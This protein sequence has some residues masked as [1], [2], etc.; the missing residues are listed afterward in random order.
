MSDR[1]L[2]GFDYPDIVVHGAESTAPAA[3]TVL[4]DSLA[5]PVAG[6]WLFIV[7]VASNDTI[8]NYI[9]IAHRNGANNADVEV[10]DVQVAAYATGI[11]YAYF[12]M[13]ASER[14][15]LRNAIVGTAAKVYQANLRGYLLR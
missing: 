5:V 4:T 12:N 11:S 3:A 8:Q 6:K 1:T 9:Q 2:L 14:V 13:A 15:V 7:D 10:Q